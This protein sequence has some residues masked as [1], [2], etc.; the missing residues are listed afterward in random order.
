MASTKKI[1][2]KFPPLS[3]P[4]PKTADPGKVRLGDTGI[5]GQF[6]PLRLPRAEIAD[7]GKVRLGDTGITGQFP[8]KK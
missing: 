1:T 5:A 3:V 6:P 8:L 7:P 2:A 4:D